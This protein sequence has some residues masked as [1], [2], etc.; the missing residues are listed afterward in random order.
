MALNALES[1]RRKF[2][3][4]GVGISGSVRDPDSSEKLWTSYT[5]SPQTA[6]EKNHHAWL[7]DSIGE[8]LVVKKC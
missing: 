2:P 7:S 4:W 5:H 3:L 6:S 8:I 1:N